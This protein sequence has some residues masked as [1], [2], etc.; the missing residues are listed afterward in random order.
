MLSNKG[1]EGFRAESEASQGSEGH[2]DAIHELIEAL[3]G[4]LFQKRGVST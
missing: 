3:S 2:L 1:V 4:F